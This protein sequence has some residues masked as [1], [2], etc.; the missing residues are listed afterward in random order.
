MKKIALLFLAIVL[1]LMLVSCGGKPKTIEACEKKVLNKKVTFSEKIV[2]PSIEEKEIPGGYQITITNNDKDAFICYWEDTS[3]HDSLWGKKDVTL[4]ANDKVVCSLEDKIVLEYKTAKKSFSLHVLAIKG[5]SSSYQSTT[6]RMISVEQMKT[7]VSFDSRTGEISTGYWDDKD[8]TYWSLNPDM[9]GASKV[10]SGSILPVDAWGKKAYFQVQG[11]VGKA[12]SEI[13]EIEVGGATIPAPSIVD[14]EDI[15]GG[16]RIYL[17]VQNLTGLTHA[18]KKT[19]SIESKA[20]GWSY[21]SSSYS[22]T[23]PEEFS[24]YYTTDGSEP[25]ETNGILCEDGIIDLTTPGDITL[26]V[27]TFYKGHS[28]KTTEKTYS[29]KKLSAPP[30]SVEGL[31]ISVSFSDKAINRSTCVFFGDDLDNLEQF[32]GTYSGNLFVDSRYVGKTLYIV[33]RDY[34][35]VDSDPIEFKV[36]SLQS[37]QENYSSTKTRQF[38][39]WIVYSEVNRKG[40]ETGSYALCARFPMGTSGTQ[41]MVITATTTDNKP[42]NLNGLVFCCP[43]KG[44]LSSATFTFTSPW[45]AAYS[46]D[47]NETEINAEVYNINYYTYEATYYVYAKEDTD[48]G[49]IKK[50]N[51]ADPFETVVKMAEGMSALDALALMYDASQYSNTSV[52]DQ[53][54]NG[55]LENLDEYSF[56]I[57]NEGLA[58][59][60][61]YYTSLKK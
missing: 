28:S 50:L 52:Q 14:Y 23:F 39:N 26:K 15:F 27:K 47:G 8:N 4:T 30:V 40:A 11:V 13:E 22:I 20:G 46:I 3:G 36:D 21:S 18:E 37:F 51:G 5:S 24:V 19:I 12:D 49:L 25:S 34:G 58:E 9:S 44:I 2:S 31:D 1:V 6:D 57:N 61:E 29:L 35:Y 38:G 55:A 45:S 32:T 54:I 59:A 60:L 7:N 41:Y 33:N 48:G 56:I 16:K 53:V 10:E 17:S 42:Y 43:S